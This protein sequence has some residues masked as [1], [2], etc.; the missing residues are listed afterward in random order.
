MSNPIFNLETFEDE[1]I[2][3]RNDLY[4]LNFGTQIE[5]VAERGAAQS[6]LAALSGLVE[7]ATAAP[8]KTLTAEEAN[9][10]YG[11]ESLKFTDP[12]KESVAQIRLERNK[13][14]QIRNR[15][16]EAA[17]TDNNTFSNISNWITEVGTAVALD[18]FTY[19]G[20]GVIN[21][22]ASLTKVARNTKL[23]AN[24]GGFIDDALLATGEVLSGTRLIGDSKIATGV[25]RG[26]AATTPD[27]ISELLVA[28]N[29][30][31]NGY[32]YNEVIGSL[33]MLGVLGINAFL[34]T[35]G[36]D[37]AFKLTERSLKN[38]SNTV[39]PEDLINSGIVNKDTAQA[40]NL[41]IARDLD[42]GVYNASEYGSMYRLD[43]ASNIYKSVE[44]AVTKGL[45]NGVE[46]TEQLLKLDPSDLYKL[47]PS[48]TL[49]G[50]IKKDSGLIADIPPDITPAQVKNLKEAES[51]IR[52]LDDAI[53]QADETLVPGL[54]AEKATYQAAKNQ[55]LI[56]KIDEAFADID[57]SNLTFDEFLDEYKALTTELKSKRIDSLDKF[58]NKDVTTRK[59]I[60][61]LMSLINP[62]D[63]E[64]EFSRMLNMDDADLKAAFTVN[65][66][67]TKALSSPAMEIKAEYI[68]RLKNREVYDSMEAKK[69][70]RN[71]ENFINN[72]SKDLVFDDLLKRA[73]QEFGQLPDDLKLELDT[74]DK[75]VD[76]LNAWQQGSQCLLRGL[77][78]G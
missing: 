40:I 42:N 41:K 39:D 68:D 1:D 66:T 3:F 64:V 34:Q 45:L 22:L 31:R 23:I 65:D 54:I 78:N 70:A 77:L 12:V 46:N 59:T 8:S 27:I 38:T 32:D 44:R 7:E 55:I 76:I 36:L 47:K 14:D 19:A 10:K 62:L 16:I 15:V 18:P 50:L 25:V 6:T 73:E 9:E 52:E 28:D 51:K 74:I 24:S 72:S 49:K 5:K 58:F 57:Y 43:I 69:A 48:L 56:T 29:A 17:N 26:F 13:A 67:A 63:E 2:D 60:A 71:T 75:E 30:K 53:R 11:T 20:G 21:G 4:K 33:A 37:E 61:K 35:K